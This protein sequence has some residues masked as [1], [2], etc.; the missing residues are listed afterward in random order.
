MTIETSVESRLISNPNEPEPPSLNSS[1]CPKP[2]ENGQPICEPCVGRRLRLQRRSPAVCPLSTCRTIRSRP[3]GVSRAFLCMFIW[4][5]PWNLKLQQPQLPRSEPDEQPNES[6]QLARCMRSYL[7]DAP[8]CFVARRDWL[9]LLVRCAAGRMRCARR[10]SDEAGAK[11]AH[12]LAAQRCSP[13][14]VEIDG[15]IPHR[16]R[17]SPQGNSCFAIT[18]P[19]AARMAHLRTMARRRFGS[20]RPTASNSNA[21]TRITINTYRLA[22]MGQWLASYKER[23]LSGS[24]VL[25]KPCANLIDPYSVAVLGLLSGRRPEALNG[26]EVEG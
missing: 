2:F 15:A 13:Q 24:A 14:Y 3:R 20:S 23:S 9:L 10:A 22:N 4:F 12:S 7:L 25:R 17:R 19:P 6:S 18:T 1:D 11:S 16:Q 8:R 5:S 26:R 21:A